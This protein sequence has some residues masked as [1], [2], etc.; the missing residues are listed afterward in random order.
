MAKIKRGAKGKKSTKIKIIAG[1]SALIFAVGG[2][3]S[4][5]VYGIQ[6]NA[7]KDYQ[8]DTDAIDTK[9]YTDTVGNEFIESGNSTDSDLSYETEET[10]QN[11]S[12]VTDETYDNSDIISD[13]SFVD[14]LANLTQVSQDYC[15]T[16][17][18]SLSQMEIVGLNSVKVN[19]N[20]V[21]LKGDFK[22]KTQFGNY[23]I[24][25]QN[26]QNPDLKIF[27]AED[28][29]DVSDFVDAINEVLH[30][31]STTFSLD[32]RQRL[33]NFDEVDKNLVAENIT[34]GLSNPDEIN[35]LSQNISN[36]S[37][38]LLLNDCVKIDNSYKYSYTV[39]VY[40]KSSV[41]ASK[42]SF[43]SDKKL[44]SNALLNK[45]K[46]HVVSSDTTCT[47]TSTS[48]N[49]FEKALHNLKNPQS[50]SSNIETVE[51]LTQQ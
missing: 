1:V 10:V 4:A 51:G 39:A 45:I 41:Y 23:I 19:G 42:F 46:D 26:S 15:A 33:I 17:R 36:A 9:P 13:P 44:T 50:K 31:E 32:A 11:P 43:V 40:T 3:I 25:L 47:T 49:S 18:T 16:N 20:E 22:N 35:N 21:S 34:K 37:Y 48:T 38:S 7:N 5:I 28:E 30:D 12:H 14:L 6:S 2:G 8:K 29:I 24:T 27:N